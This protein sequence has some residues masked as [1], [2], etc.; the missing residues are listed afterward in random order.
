M[1]HLARKARADL[2]LVPIIFIAALKFT[3]QIDSI[4]DLSGFDETDYLLQGVRLPEL[5]VDG[6]SLKWAPLYAAWYYLL[7]LVESDRISLYYLNYKLLVTA[8]TLLF[9]LLLR[10]LSVN[11]SFAGAA[12]AFYLLSNIPQASPYISLFALLVM[13]LFF[14]W[15]VR[16]SSDE[17]FYLIAGLGLLLMSFVRAEYT[18]A[19][20][21]LLGMLLLVYIFSPRLGPR[22]TDG[23]SLY[24]TTFFLVA[25]ITLFYFFGNPLAGDKSWEAFGQHFT[26][27]YV[28]WYGAN[29]P[30]D[31]EART[32]DAFGEASSIGQA[33]IMNTSLFTR[34]VLANAGMLPLA[35]ITM[36]FV[37]PFSFLSAGWHGLIAWIQLSGFV[38]IAVFVIRRALTA[39]HMT[40]RVVC[41]RFLVVCAIVCIPNII[42]AV[43]IYPRWHYLVIPA[44]VILALF[45][46]FFSAAARDAYPQALKLREELVAA[47]LLLGIP[48]LAHGWLAPAGLGPGEPSLKAEREKQVL[49]SSFYSTIPRWSTIANYW[50]A[51]PFAPNEEGQRALENR[52]VVDYILSLNISSKVNILAGKS[53]GIYLTDNYLPVHPWEKEDS[54]THFLQEKQIG[55][56]LVQDF[57]LT[58][59]SFA[60]DTEFHD[61]L[62]EVESHGFVETEIPGAR[63][64]LFVKSLLWEEGR[65]GAVPP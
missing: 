58:Y 43:V 37:T 33:V 8:T 65:R 20:I 59:P 24:K 57:L 2:V 9:Y 17:D 53:Y 56:I 27:H 54:F 35:L 5:L 18:V 42:S 22:L 15:A 13:L 14:N 60:K 52:A 12:S 30:M 29:N 64:P 21:L 11:S 41:R 55:M 26:I 23:T 40:K 38:C 3:Y 28:D 47:V 31:W 10:G 48:N 7:S 49:Q 32:T 45:W 62:R 25:A 63:W 61:F 1:L 16:S 39:S 46:A 6:G 51:R 19:F 50:L 44:T 4:H 36:P 34:H